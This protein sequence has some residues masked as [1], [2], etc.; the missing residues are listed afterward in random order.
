[1]WLEEPKSEREALEDKIY[2]LYPNLDMSE[3]ERMTDDRLNGLVARA[4]G[5]VQHKALKPPS[6]KWIKVFDKYELRNGQLVQVETWRK[7]IDVREKIEKCGDRVL[8][9]GRQ[10][11]ASILKHY[12]TTGDWVKR[13]PKPK[14][15]KAILSVNGK[16]VYL[17]SFATLEEKEAAIFQYKIGIFAKKA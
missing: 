9:E 14:K 16:S 5:K 3:I 7:G 10:I 15:V 8:Y 6:P 13:V 12:L 11:S 1:M 2:D 4:N 17:G